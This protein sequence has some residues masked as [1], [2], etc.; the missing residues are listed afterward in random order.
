[1]AIVAVGCTEDDVDQ[2]ITSSGVGAF[3]IVASV[4][5]EE[6]KVNVDGLEVSWSSSDELCVAEV[7][8]DGEFVTS[9]TYYIDEE[10][11]SEDGKYAEFTGSALIQGREYIAYS[12]T[13]G[14]EITSETDYDFE[15]LIIAPCDYSNIVMQSNI[16]EWDGV[17]FPQLYFQHKSSILDLNITLEDGSDYVGEIESVT[18][19]N[20]SNRDIF[21]STPLFNSYG[22]YEYKFSQSSQESQYGAVSSIELSERFA[23]DSNT[24]VEIRVPL[25]WNGY[26]TDIEG[27]FT[28]TIKTTDG[29]ECEVTK[30][31]QR[32]EDGVRYGAELTF[33]EP[34]SVSLVDREALIDL[35]NSTN[36]DNWSSKNNWCSEEPLGDWHGVT[37]DERGRVT[38]LDLTWCSLSGSIPASIGDLTSITYLDL[39]GNSL[40]GS[41][42]SEIGDLVNLEY[43]SLCINQ[44]S[45]SVPASLGNLTK[46]INLN[47][48]Y[49]NLEGSL[50]EE[51][52]VL[53]KS[54]T[55][56][57][58]SQNRFTGIIP[59]NFADDQDAWNQRAWE[60]VPQQD[61]YNFESYPSV[62][63]T[64]TTITTY[65]G[66]T[67]ETSEFFAENELVCILDWVTGCYYTYC[68]IETLKGLYETYHDYGF[69]V[70]G[71]CYQDDTASVQSYV[72]DHSVPWH[73]YQI[74][75]Y[76]GSMPYF[77]YG[78]Y[79]MYHFVDKTGAIVFS[80]SLDSTGSLSREEYTQQFV[81]EWFEDVE[82]P[83]IYESTDYSADGTYTTLQKAS[84]GT[85]IDLVIMGDGFVDK[86]MGVGGTYEAR[87]QETMDA[88]FSEEPYV[89][90]KDRFNVY[91][92]NVVSKNE[93]IGDD[94]DSALDVW[95]GSGTA[96]GGSDQTCANYMSNIPLVSTTDITVIIAVNSTNYAGTCYMY[97]NGVSFAYCPYAYNSEDNYRQLVTHEAGGHGFAKLSDEY[98]YSGAITTEAIDSYIWWRD[99]YGYGFNVD[100]T[101]DPD[102]ILWSHMLSDSRYDGLVDIYE[103]ALT[104]EFGA[105][106][107]TDSSIMRY[108]VGGYNPPSREAIYRKIME[109]SGDT[110]D[111]ENFVEYD[112][113]NR[114]AQSMTVRVSQ[115]QSVDRETFVP[116]APPVLNMK[117]IK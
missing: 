99:Y 56:V 111:Y 14:C 86:D 61:G 107:P 88:F 13:K 33:V 114:S 92:V 72:D 26:I 8:T 67:I 71:S 44:L 51:L 63:V 93:G 112:A 28:F 106:R 64:P 54:T 110:Y 1:M 47:L 39:G 22:E 66:E 21:L 70:L 102:D 83:A 59:D 12:N 95:F 43:L 36:G 34:I 69:D 91:A 50:P 45:G 6:T 18:I 20:D 15:N 55:N 42:P 30:P 60:I 10:S 108:N 46:L 81:E 5:T 16:F 2:Y 35:Y 77:P 11:I 82:L 37:T 9:Y 65:A 19:S 103:G 104:Y 53:I 7:G 113:I 80:G 75:Y 49:C 116:L 97:S 105:Y 41:I 29:E 48:C 90:Y 84:V 38:K 76:D 74:G 87:M 52:S 24:T 96:I 79:P 117:A 32:L 115:T 89:T 40:T 62:Y 23:F 27:N 78:S 17:T 57:Y 58:F 98:A 85:G 94:L 100:V 31:L 4:S 25:T 101:N 73:I 109:L 68:Y 3:R